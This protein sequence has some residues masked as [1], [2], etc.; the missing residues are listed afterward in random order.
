MES[1]FGDVMILLQIATNYYYISQIT[2]LI[3]YQFSLNCASERQQ[4]RLFGVEQ[5]EDGR[6]RQFSRRSQL[7]EPNPHRSSE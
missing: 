6:R 7:S 5:N 1:H 3:V 2:L 4:W